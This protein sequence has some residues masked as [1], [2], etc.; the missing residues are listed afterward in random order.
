M[1]NQGPPQPRR[2]EAVA[3]VVDNDW[4]IGGDPLLLHECTEYTVVRGRDLGRDAVIDGRMRPRRHKGRPRDVAGEIVVI[5]LL[6]DIIEGI[7]SEHNCKTPMCPM[8]FV[9]RSYA[10]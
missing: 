6:P 9:S 10:G 1:V 4:P 8:V 5:A 7:Y 2:Q 3:G